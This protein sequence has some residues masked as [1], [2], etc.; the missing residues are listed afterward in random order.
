MNKPSSKLLRR[1]AEQRL[2][3][4]ER[5][6]E[7]LELADLP[8]LAHEF[9][10]K[11]ATIE[12]QNEELRIESERAEEARDRYLDL[13]EFAPVGYYTLDVK[14]RISEANQ[15]GCRLLTVPRQSQHY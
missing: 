13:F 8:S 11:Q 5:Q 2:A 4:T 12:I 10:L 3:K 6:I 9:A 7:S 15:A 1:K 14:N